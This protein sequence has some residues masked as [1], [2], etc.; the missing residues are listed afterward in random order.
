MYNV[1]LLTLLL[2]LLLLSPILSLLLLLLL[3]LLSPP[4]PPL[5]SS[6]LWWSKLMSSFVKWLDYSQTRFTRTT[7]SLFLP[8]TQLPQLTLFLLVHHTLLP[9]YLNSLLRWPSL[10]VECRAACWIVMT[11]LLILLLSRTQ[12]MP[13]LSELSHLLPGAARR[14]A[15]HDR[16]THTQTDT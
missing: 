2:L 13:C 11:C 15:S 1:F 5:V 12:S 4:P 8:P 9:R 14:W 7:H 16:Q 10:W 3:P 6:G